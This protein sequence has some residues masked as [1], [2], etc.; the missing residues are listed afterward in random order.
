LYCGILAQDTNCE[1]SKSPLLRNDRYTRNDIKQEAVARQRQVKDS[2]TERKFFSACPND[3]RVWLLEEVFSAQFVTK[4]Y[5]REAT[6]RETSE[7]VPGQ[8]KHGTL[9]FEVGEA[10]ELRQ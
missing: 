4:N 5:K 9:A 3:P 1:A 6:M 8:N 2:R 10:S 7:N